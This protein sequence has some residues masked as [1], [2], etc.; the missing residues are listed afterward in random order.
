MQVSRQ[1]CQSCGTI[2]VRNILVREPGQATMVYVRCRQCKSLV[3]SYELSGYY[4]HGK[5][6]E[7]YLRAHGAAAADSGRQWLDEF[8][9]V[10]KRAVA[11]YEAALEQLSAEQKEI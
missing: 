5:G 4:H 2:D 1:T 10:Q 9:R 8:Q 6:I 3:A 7:S 11:G